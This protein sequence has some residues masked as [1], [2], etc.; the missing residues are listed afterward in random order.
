LGFAADLLAD[1]RKFDE[2]SWAKKE[3]ERE[4]DMK[5]PEHELKMAFVSSD[6]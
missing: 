5:S 1:C 3:E 6:F 2:G 4:A